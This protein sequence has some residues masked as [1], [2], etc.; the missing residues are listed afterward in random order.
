MANEMEA[1]ARE[2]LS[3]TQGNGAVPSLDGF[4]A[5]LKTAEGQKLA[6]G[7]SGS[8]ED[9]VKTAAQAALGGDSQTARVAMAKFLSTREGAE[10]MKNLSAVMNGGK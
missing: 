8:G 10:L 1:L 9:T 7:L 5:V 4:M 3:G 2:L 6:S